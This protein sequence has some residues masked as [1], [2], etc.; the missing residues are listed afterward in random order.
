MV[1]VPLCARFHSRTLNYFEFEYV[2]KNEG[3][4]VKR[5]HLGRVDWM[6][7]ISVSTNVI[8]ITKVIRNSAPSIII[9]F[10]GSRLRI[11]R[12]LLYYLVLL[13]KCWSIFVFFLLLF[14]FSTRLP[15]S[16]KCARVHFRARQFVF[17]TPS[18]TADQ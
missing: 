16:N 14:L 15:F 13:S 12:F 18:C 1:L 3:V 9:H 7:A 10:G 11:S 6:N 5:Y 8:Y 4:E 17:D 2:S